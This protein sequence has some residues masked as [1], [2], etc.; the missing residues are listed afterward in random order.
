MSLKKLN[1]TT[2]KSR[3]LEYAG[4]GLRVV[5]LHTIADGH[6]SC[7]SGPDCKRPGKHPHTPK[8]VKD[9]TNRRKT[10]KA[11]WN[12][13]PD[14]NIGI[15]TGVRSGIF[16]LDVDGDVGK[17]SLKALQAKHGQLP[18][19]MTVQ[20]GKGRHRYFRCDGAHVGNSVGKLGEGIDVRGD[21]GYVVGV[22]SIHVSGTTY[23]FVDERGPEE[24]KVALAPEWLLNLVTA[25]DVARE[26]IE[27]PA[28]PPEKLDR[29]RSYADAALRRELDRLGKAPQH[30]R[31]DTLNRTAFKLGQ[32]LPYAILDRQK[33]TD[34]LARVARS[35]GLDDGEIQPTIASGLDAGSSSPRRLPFIKSDL[36]TAE[37]PA[38]SK[39]KVTEELA[40]LGE[41]DTDN[42]QRFATRFG[43]TV[44]NT[45]G[46]GWLVYDGRRWLPD[47]LLKVKE[48]AKDAARLV[49]DEA[50]FLNEDKART[51]RRSFATQ[52]LSTGALDR[53]LESAKSLLAIEDSRLDADAWLLNVE[54][55][56]I[57]LRTGRREKHDSR[58]L[59]T[60]IVP[61]RANRKAKCP[62]FKKF[63][64]R[65]TAN[66]KELQLFIKKCVGYTLTGDMSEQV[67][68]FVHGASGNNG[69]STLI[70]LI[71]K[72]LGD[73]GIHTPT[74][75]FLVKQ[76]DNNIPAD[77]ARLAGARMVTAIEA[78]ANRQIDEAKIKGITGGEPITAR[79]MRENFFQFAPEFKLW[80]VANDRPRVRGT[81]DAFWRRVRLIPLNVAIPADEVD[82]D[83][84]VKLQAEWPGILAWAV[85]GCQKW[86]K[87]KLLQPDA[88]REATEAWHSEMD[89]IKQFADEQ[90]IVTPGM[91]VAASTLFDLY[92]N[93][94]LQHGEHHLTVQEFKAKFGESLDITHKRSKGR[95][96]WKGIQIRH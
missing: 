12:K 19:T 55:G 48:L 70:N 80:F 61:V 65:I 6:C 49:A 92:K 69:K 52:S 42:G 93:W 15:A 11:W 72:M 2:R 81:D 82:P 16:V 47:D 40:A 8:G 89:H 36:P 25:K 44:I 50:A 17:E 30:Q 76:Y 83:L 87:E 57:N 34:D 38:K 27:L 31:N 66:D 43:T 62:L 9:A 45:P 77:L 60:K 63:L 54:N 24:I 33:V 68:F 95:S 74:D 73:Y 10:I 1:I 3:A 39:D 22:G 41:T 7:A 59:L 90:V 14:A 94:C 20:T 84:P 32:L 67:F 21:G 78:N 35:I 79:F 28:V 86:Q 85:R 46:R 53:M 4:L 64:R 58:D 71:R 51:A 29:A 23:K 18:K 91:K 37:P 56:T 5:P 96:Y 13:W 75:S 26:V 88:I